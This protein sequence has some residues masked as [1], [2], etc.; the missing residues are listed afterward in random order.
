M[1]GAE[2]QAQRT[3]RA[4]SRNGQR[5]KVNGRSCEYQPRSSLDLSTCQ[6]FCIERKGY[7]P[8]SKKKTLDRSRQ[9]INIDIVCPTGRLRR[10]I[11]K[12]IM[13]FYNLYSP[14]MDKRTDGW[15]DAWTDGRTDGQADGRTGGRTD[16]RTDGCF[17][18]A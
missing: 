17:N 16:E 3:L 13:A 18:H 5:L 15:T 9:S 14:K 10:S 7:L 11:Q 12:E 2:L 8:K 4:R 6:G 1:R